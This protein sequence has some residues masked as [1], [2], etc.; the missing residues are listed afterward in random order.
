MRSSLPALFLVLAAGCA[1][2]IDYGILYCNSAAD[3]CAA[4]GETDETCL[5]RVSEAPRAATEADSTC[6]DAAADCDAAQA[7]WDT[8][9]A[10]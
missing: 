3:V 8:L 9:E 5:Q 10:G 1:P 4:E 2:T 7:C 6:M